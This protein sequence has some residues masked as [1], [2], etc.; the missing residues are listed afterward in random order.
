MVSLR[1]VD[2]ADVCVF[3]DLFMCFHVDRS[4]I[5]VTIWICGFIRNYINVG[6]PFIK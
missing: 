1:S 2:T 3:L 6:Q 5:I 4:C